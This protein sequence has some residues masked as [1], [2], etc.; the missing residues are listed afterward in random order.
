MESIP[1]S[2]PTLTSVSTGDNSLVRFTETQIDEYF[3][4][5]A[6]K[7]NQNKFKTALV[8]ALLVLTGFAQAEI[9][10]TRDQYIAKYGV[11]RVE[12]GKLTP[13]GTEALVINVSGR[14]GGAV[15]L[16]AYLDRGTSFAE[17]YVI[18]NGTSP[19]STLDAVLGRGGWA[20]MS[21]I[22][23]LQ[24][25]GQLD[26]AILTM[27]NSN[28]PGKYA[29]FKIRQVDVAYSL[30]IVSQ[31]P[32][33]L[34]AAKIE[35]DPVAKELTLV[36]G[37]PVYL[38]PEEHDAAV[39]SQKSSTTDTS[40]SAEPPSAPAQD[41][42]AISESHSTLWITAFIIGAAFTAGILLLGRRLVFKR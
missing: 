9:G 3:L 19:A 15:T 6:A 31:F 14:I 20:E 5:S 24:Q 28:P 8:L 4:K 13:S 27:W 40:K 39:R 12:G 22:E 34:E 36:D 30:L 16:G 29:C 1:L 23:P 41:S 33:T 26:P 11:D 32:D 25:I 38:T 37:K 7:L 18:P 2:Q 42:A 17:E 21:N 35:T 10:W